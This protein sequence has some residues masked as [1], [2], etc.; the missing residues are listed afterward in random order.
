ML[1]FAHISTKV[2]ACAFP[3]LIE[4]LAR[5]LLFNRFAG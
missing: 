1:T 4:S 5:H 2:L 3:T